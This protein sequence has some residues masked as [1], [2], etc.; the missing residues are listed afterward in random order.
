MSAADSPTPTT[1]NPAPTLVTDGQVRHLAQ[2][3]LNVTAGSTRTMELINVATDHFA[4][5]AAHLMALNVTLQVITIADSTG[6]LL[7]CGFGGVAVCIAE[8]ISVEKEPSK[9]QWRV[10]LLKNG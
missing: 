1:T 5:V 4:R 7:T 2:A 10:Q 9:T 8:P 3:L 6:R